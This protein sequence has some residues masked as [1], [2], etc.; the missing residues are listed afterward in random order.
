MVGLSAVKHLVG[1]T[2]T[3]NLALDG[4]QIGPLL[5]LVV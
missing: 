1:D 5:S 4:A 2:L 3:L